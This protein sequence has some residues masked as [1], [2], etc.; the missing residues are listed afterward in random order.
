MFAGVSCTSEQ[1]E[2]VRLRVTPAEGP[3]GGVQRE[4]EW[5]SNTHFNILV[6]P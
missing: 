3:N 4:R 5:V 6:I 2:S 1:H